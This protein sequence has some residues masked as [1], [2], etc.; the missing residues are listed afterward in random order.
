MP[1]QEQSLKLHR[2]ERGSHRGHSVFP[3]EIN[4]MRRL[5]ILFSAIYASNMIAGFIRGASRLSTVWAC[6]SRSHFAQ[7]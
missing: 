1:N 7:E 3:L 2:M 5:A 6:Y 4:G